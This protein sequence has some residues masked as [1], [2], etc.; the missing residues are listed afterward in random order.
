MAVSIIHEYLMHAVYFAPRGR[1]RLLAL[2]SNL[3]QR[4]LSPEDHLIGFIGDAGAGKSLLIRGMFPGLELTNDDDGINV[5]PLPLLDD[6]DRKQF[7]ARTYHLDVRFE[8]AFSQPWTIVEAIQEAIKHDRRVIVEHFDLIYPML[9]MNAHILI[10]IG[11]EVIVTR[12]NIFGPEPQEIADIV[13]ESLIYRKM[14]HTAEDITG[15]VLEEEMGI[16]KPKVHSDIKHGFVLEFEEKPNIDLDV[17][18]KR[19]QEII[20]NDLSIYY[21]DEA[22]IKV[23]DSAYPCTGPRLHVKRTSEITNFR[24]IKEF[25]WDP[26]AELYVLVGLIGPVPEGDTPSTPPDQFQLIRRGRRR[27]HEMTR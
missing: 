6:F 12:P 25:L 27:A 5:R 2:G 13:F 1:Y 23:G 21:H 14:A 19:V 3:A 17:L 26:T 18:E 7:R 24:L 20:K 9:K 8:M 4:Y 16:K 11:E 22:H 10:G 15:K